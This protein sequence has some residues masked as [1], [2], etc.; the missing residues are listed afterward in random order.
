MYGLSTVEGEGDLELY[1]IG[2]D[3]GSASGRLKYSIGWYVITFSAV[4][5][6]VSVDLRS[7]MY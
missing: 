6:S 5:V 2:E 1:V 4:S 7:Y 3:E